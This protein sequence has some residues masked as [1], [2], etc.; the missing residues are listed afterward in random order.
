MG[1]IFSANDHDNANTFL[2]ALISV[3]LFGCL[4]F[5]IYKRFF[6]KS[7]ARSKRNNTTREMANPSFI[8]F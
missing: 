4:V 8:Q 5:F 2:L 1:E 7:G 6:D 3:V